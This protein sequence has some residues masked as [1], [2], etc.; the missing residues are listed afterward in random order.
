MAIDAALITALQRNSLNERARS[1]ASHPQA[2]S[3]AAA[4]RFE[5]ILDKLEKTEGTGKA[6]AATA[7]IMQLE[8]MRNALTLDPAAPLEPMTSSSTLPLEFI[9]AEALQSKVPVEVQNDEKQVTPNIETQPIIHAK[10]PAQ[11][12]DAIINSAARKYGVDQ[13]LIKA[14]IRVESNFNPSAVSHAGAQGL[15]QLMPSTA[16]GLGVTNSFDP[17][18]NV[19]GGTRFLKDML[20]RYGGNIDKALAAYNWGPG[21]VDKGTRALPKETREYLVKVK[22]L[23]NEYAV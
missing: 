14:V 2:A 11:H 20:E 17:V 6:V 1:V 10:E 18:Q 8:M 12:L 19:M 9:L 16:R 13:A 22:Q 7:E 4:N 3:P 15:M 21:N 5:A 23:Y